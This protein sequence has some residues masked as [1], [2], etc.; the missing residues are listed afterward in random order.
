MSSV[1]SLMNPKVG[2]IIKILDTHT[3]TRVAAHL[4]CLV[5]RS[6]LCEGGY[7]PSG[8]RY[9]IKDAK[10]IFILL[11]SRGLTGLKL[12]PEHFKAGR[13]G[14]DSRARLLDEV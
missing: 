9:D 4:T 2:S 13:R 8:I 14:A 11:A 6:S 7:D 3:H 12:H 10:Q 1:S 5:H